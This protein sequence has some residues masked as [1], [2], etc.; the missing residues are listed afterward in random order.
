MT[1]LLKKGYFTEQN[2]LILTDIL[3]STVS[4]A[5]RNLP[6]LPQHRPKT[7]NPMVVI[8]HIFPFFEL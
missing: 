2:I 1:S 3:L 5:C 4:F 7:N 6:F 8:I